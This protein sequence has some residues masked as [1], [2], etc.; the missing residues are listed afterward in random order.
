[1]KA[2]N[3]TLPPASR[4]VGKTY[5]R[6]RVCVGRAPTRSYREHMKSNLHKRN[7]AARDARENSERVPLSPPMSADVPQTFD[8]DMEQADELVFDSIGLE[9]CSTRAESDSDYD[10]FESLEPAA[11]SLFNEGDE[12]DEPEEPEINWDD[13]LFEAVNQLSDGNVPADFGFRQ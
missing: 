1:M 10:P 2:D 4:E 12:A 11:Y 5:Y 13:Y 9:H 3:P 7:V 6:C 8:L